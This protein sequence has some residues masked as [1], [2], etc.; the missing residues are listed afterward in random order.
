[1]T[2]GGGERDGEPRPDG[3]RSELSGSS[4]DVVQTGNVSGGIHFHH[5][6]GPERSGLPRPRQLPG[7][8]S[9]F[10][11][12]SDETERLDAILTADGDGPHAA[13]VCVITGTA[14]VGKTSLALRWAHRIANRF[15]DGQLYLNLR[16]YDPGAPVTAQEALHR[17][18]SALGVPPGSIAADAD[19]DAAAAHY[20]S[21][22]ADR[23]VLVVLDN[24]ASAAQVR[25]LLPGGAHCL[26][27][28]TSRSRLSGLAIREGAHRLPLRTLP[29]G[30]AVALL[31]A[32]TSGYRH[33]DD[34]AKLA[35]LAGL[36]AHLPLA[37][38]I[39]AERAAAHPHLRLDDLLAELRDESAS[40]LGHGT[41][42]VTRQAGMR[43]RRPA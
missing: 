10:V 25:P 40:V 16:G 21:L 28:V 43:S 8:I 39:A 30:E 41:G 27:I 38:R 14:G 20:R 9:R 12:R 36:C 19:A 34:A 33:Q 11:D 31:R 29:E 4:R 2:I 23:R 15:P 5:D 13:S 3:T 17:F 7:C 32:V 22:L 42:Y 18:L 24:A 26:T 35:E 37:L 6:D 1:V